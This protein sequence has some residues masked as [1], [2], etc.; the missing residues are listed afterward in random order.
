[1]ADALPAVVVLS[2]LVPR[3]WGFRS[4][5]CFSFYGIVVVLSPTWAPAYP[6]LLRVVGLS[7]FMGSWIYRVPRADS[8]CYELV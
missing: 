2:H 3:R 1:M 7:C 6:D 8:L 4:R 5:I